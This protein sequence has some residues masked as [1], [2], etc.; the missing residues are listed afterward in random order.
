MRH[1]T[2]ALVSCGSAIT[3]LT[4]A[5]CV[6]LF[7]RSRPH[8]ALWPAEPALLR[9]D[10]VKVLADIRRLMGAAV[11]PVAILVSQPRMVLSMADAGMA[12]ALDVE[13]Y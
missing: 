4:H 3:A 10:I 6:C 13:G 1:C 7:L 8:S 2:R 11:D 5:T 9:A 12:S